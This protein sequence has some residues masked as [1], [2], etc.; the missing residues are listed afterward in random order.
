MVAQS[1]ARMKAR[2]QF[3]F[4]LDNPLIQQVGSGSYMYICVSAG[5]K[6]EKVSHEVTFSAVRTD[7]LPVFATGVPIVAVGIVPAKKVGWFNFFQEVTDCE[8][9][10]RVD[11]FH[12]VQKNCLEFVVGFASKRHVNVTK[13]TKS[14]S[15]SE[16]SVSGKV[17]GS[18]HAVKG[19]GKASISGSHTQTDQS[20]T[21]TVKEYN[22]EVGTGLSIT[23][24]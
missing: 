16:G 2:K 9:H 13:T 22:T 14:G 6:E 3:V 4:K 18:F 23:Q 7:P 5:Q 17:A 19:S 8:H 11:N 24:R 20:S 12:D 1:G 21:K 10:G 15:S